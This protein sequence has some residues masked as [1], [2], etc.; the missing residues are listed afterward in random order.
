MINTSVTKVDTCLDKE[1]S[2][3]EV[4]D[5][6]ALIQVPLVRYEAL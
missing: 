5:I 3:Y 6:T 1:H 2:I 4:G